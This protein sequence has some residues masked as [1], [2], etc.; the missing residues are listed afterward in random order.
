MKRMFLLLPLLV[1][2]SDAW[3]WRC[4]GWIIEENMLRIEVGEKCGN[5]EKF[6]RRTEWRLQTQFQQQCEIRREPVQVPSPN[7][8]IGKHG[9]VPAA[10]QMTYQDKTYCYSV[11]VQITVPVEVEEWLYPVDDQDNVPHLLHFEA[12]RLI[13]VETLWD[14]RRL[15]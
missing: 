10:P 8:V 7:V 5:P 11:P 9:P 6:D 3:A 14:Q 4:N 13:Q 2:A 12:G 1:F 15:H